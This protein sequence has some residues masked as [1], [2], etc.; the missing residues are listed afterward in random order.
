MSNADPFLIAA[1][2]PPPPGIDLAED[3]R[4]GGIVLTVILLLF[5]ILIV[6]LRFTAKGGNGARLHAD[7]YTI[8]V[9]LVMCVAMA[10]INIMAGQAGAGLHVWAVTKDMLNSVA[11]ITFVCAFFWISAVSITKLSILL[12]YRRLFAANR[13]RFR[14]WIDFLG[15]VVVCHMMVIIVVNLI[16][17]RPLTYVWS[18]YTPGA[19]GTCINQPAYGL[20]RSITNACLDIVVLATPIPSIWKLQVS[21]KRRLVIC[22]MMLLGG[23]VC[24]ASWIRVYYIYRGTKTI[25]STWVGGKIATMSFIE[26]SLGIV[27]ACL[28]VM[29]PLFLKLQRNYKLYILSRKTSQGDSS[30]SVTAP[31]SAPKVSHHGHED[32]INLTTIISGSDSSERQDCDRVVVRSEIRQAEAFV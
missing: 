11:K 1:V 5:T 2:G 6:V 16:A 14:M 3:H 12:L 17:C 10:C 25:D 9:A 30:A 18:R 32:T 15:V 29:R 24:I 7:D 20:I 4:T 27:S 21:V 8:L 19:R 26:T 28:P 31:A 23:I 22:G 13:T